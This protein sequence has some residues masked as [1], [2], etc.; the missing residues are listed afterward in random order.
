M[1][2][3]LLLFGMLL[4]GIVLGTIACNPGHV[5]LEARVRN[6]LRAVNDFDAAKEF[7]TPLMQEAVDKYGSGAGSSAMPGA[8][9]VLQQLGSE[10]L[11][12]V[13]SGNIEVQGRGKWA[14]V[15]I[16]VPT[17]YGNEP[18]P[19]IWLKIGTTWYLFSGSGGE[20]AE[21]GKPPYFAK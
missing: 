7:L 8:T 10:A 11:S 15:T 18:V 12:K 5:L 20:E 2:F 19:T 3:R 17:E 21:Y 16:F 4:T 9:P 1:A 13:G 6:Y 14:Q